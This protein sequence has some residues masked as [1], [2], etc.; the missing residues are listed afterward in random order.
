MADLTKERDLY[1][2]EDH[3]ATNQYDL[4]INNAGAGIYG[5]FAGIP[6]KIILIR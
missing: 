5:P 2:L 1:A 3:L 6:W 4:L